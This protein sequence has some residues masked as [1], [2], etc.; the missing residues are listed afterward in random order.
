MDSA[1]SASAGDDLPFTGSEML[2]Y[3]SELDSILVSTGTGTMVHL[4][5]GGGAV[6]AVKTDARLTTDV[7]VV[8]EGM[9]EQLRQ[10]VAEVSR[11]H[12]GLRPDWLN[13]GA[14]LHRVSLPM[15]PERLYTGERLLID[16]AGDRYVLVMKLAS[17]R[18]IDE[19]DCEILIRAIG[20]RTESEL[21][22]LIEQGVP[23]DLRIPAM[24]YFAAER[25]AHAYAGTSRRH[26]PREASS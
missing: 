12:R 21:F 3:F 26:N 2:R 7:D 20:I 11:R 1:E 5:V 23:A 9:T 10:C 22:D 4:Y 18:Q 17:G 24:A 25:L 14:K 6:I 13:D 16:S 8:S 15:E 19:A